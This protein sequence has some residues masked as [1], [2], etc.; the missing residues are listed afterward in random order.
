MERAAGFERRNLLV[1]VQDALPLELRP[2]KFV[3]LYLPFNRFL[4][5]SQE[6]YILNN[7][8]SNMSDIKTSGEKHPINKYNPDVVFSLFRL[9]IE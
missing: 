5:F 3:N 2:H 7:I 1:G 6:E 9:K 8:I 4:C